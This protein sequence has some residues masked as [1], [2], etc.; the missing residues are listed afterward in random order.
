AKPRLSRFVSEQT[1]NVHLDGVFSCATIALASTSRAAARAAAAEALLSLA[2]PFPPG[3]TFTARRNIDMPPIIGSALVME[4]PRP[5]PLSR[6][7]IM[8]G[9]SAPDPPMNFAAMVIGMKLEA[10]M[11]VAFQLIDPP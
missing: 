1:L 4:E 3:A 11:A 2:F 9:F 10:S 7:L 5:L 8:A 6:A